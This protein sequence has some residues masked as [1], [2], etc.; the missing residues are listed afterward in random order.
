LYFASA[1]QLKLA[2]DAI[3]RAQD[4]VAAVCDRVGKL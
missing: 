1:W 3:R 4:P 2:V